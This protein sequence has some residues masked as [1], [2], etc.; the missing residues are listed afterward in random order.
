M[1]PIAIQVRAKLMSD[2][3]AGSYALLPPMS[4]RYGPNAG[5]ARNVAIVY[6]PITIASV[7]NAPDSN[8][9]RRLGR[10]TCQRIRTQPAPRLWDA[11]VR[12][13]M[14]IERSPTSTARYMYGN[15]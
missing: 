15:E 11:S 5:R 12:L 2:A 9:T 1:R 8:D 6:S 7:R 14:S 10:M 13:W 3:A 4:E